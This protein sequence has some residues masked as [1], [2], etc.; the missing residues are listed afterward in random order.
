MIAE[1][2]SYQTGAHLTGIVFIIQTIQDAIESTKMKRDRIDFHVA[3]R[4]EKMLRHKKIPKISA[5]REAAV[6]NSLS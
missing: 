6:P 5:R 1:Y 2:I 4:P 3:I